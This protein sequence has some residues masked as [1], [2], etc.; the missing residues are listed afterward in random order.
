MLFP[1]IG[2]RQ[3]LSDFEEK[4]NSRGEEVRVK[5]GKLDNLEVTVSKEAAR[6][7]DHPCQEQ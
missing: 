4:Q 5:W 1:S 7:D 2:K 3:I 6:V